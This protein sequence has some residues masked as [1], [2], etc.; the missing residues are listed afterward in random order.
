MIKLSSVLVFALSVLS[1]SS[2]CRAEEYIPAEDAYF[3]ELPVVLTASRLSQHF[4]EAPSAMTVIDREMI[5]ASGFRS[6]PELMRLVPG[7]YVGFADANRPVASFHGSADELAHRMQILVDGR[8]IYMPPFGAVS[9]SDL[10]LLVEDIERIEVVRGPASASY[11]TNSFYG[12]I[13]IITRDALSQDGASVSV[14]AGY[15]AD[16]SARYGKT[17]EH[18][19]Y[20]FSVGYRS[21]AG[22]E[23]GVMNDHNAT[24]VFNLRSNY[25]PTATDSLDVQLG[26]SNGVYGSGIV[27]RDDSLFRN[28]TAQSD[29]QQVSWNHIW[30]ANGE[31]KLTYSHSS[32][33]S[34]DP[35]V[36][37]DIAACDGKK[38]PDK[39]VAQGFVQPAVYSQ[40]NE[41]EVQNTNQFGSRNRLVWGGS[42]R[43]DY[44]DYPLYLAKSYMV[45]SWQVFAHD[46]LRVTYDSVLNIG[47]MYE[48]N[49]M[50]NRN[51][52]PRAS[53]NYHLTPQHTVRVGISTA[54][55][56]P[57]IF[58]AY[59]DANN[60]ILGGAY[61]PPIT[62]LV[63]EKVLSKEVGY[64][65]EFRSLGL[66]IDARAYI[67]QVR[68]M[69]WWDKYVAQSATWF[70]DSYKNLISAEYKGVD[71]TV[72][73]RWNEGF[74]FWV[75]NYAFQQ[76]SATLGH[77]PTQYYNS[78]PD[79]FDP[80][81]Y[82]SIGDR[83][84]QFYQNDYLANYS[85]T[86]PTHS[87]SFLLSQRIADTWQMSGGYYARWGV[88]VGDVSPD[89]TPEYRMQR[90][91]LRLAKIFNL[92]KGKKAEIAL[93]VQN[94]TQESYT[95]Y[96]TLNVV[97]EVAFMRRGW[98]TAAVN[99]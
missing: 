76:A 21:D 71:A 24:K 89:V 99:F 52:S 32:R 40:R 93:V 86:V 51:N 37:V 8:S 28:T 62:P 66:T 77:I 48:D 81:R 39:T 59:V 7:M 88:R 33:N 23:N 73:C 41:M 42:M 60:T 82:S 56:S 13:N 12:A 31:S 2:P 87:Y 97:A 46:E 44:A 78:M 80:D 30:A 29:F 67:D 90:V 70:P 54:T 34:F 15:A 35:L 26:N 22:L 83:V 38:M 27:G 9:W 55:R 11:G 25:R 45:N 50:G 92:N 61:V 74:D 79:P 17:G 4:S 14:T 63:P 10:P 68:D 96:G 84:R 36:C 16:A 95:K 72:K 20:R 69:I 19:D 47:T 3:Q 18:F 1:S 85:Q 65:G 91:D 49:G 98:L 6:V 53:F 64:I 94:A 57:A 58:E 5:R 43:H 75:L